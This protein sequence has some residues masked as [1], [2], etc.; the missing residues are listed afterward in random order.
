VHW[1]TNRAGDWSTVRTFAFDHRL[2]LDEM[3]G[4]TLE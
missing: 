1:A 3:E 2:Q 4:Y